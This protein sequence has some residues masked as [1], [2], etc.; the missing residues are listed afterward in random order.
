MSSRSSGELGD[1]MYDTPSVSLVSVSSPAIAVE[2]GEP[3]AAEAAVTC[4]FAF[5]SMFSVLLFLAG[6]PLV[7]MGVL[8]LTGVTT[9]LIESALAARRRRSAATAARALAVPERIAGREARETYRAILHVYAEIQRE[10]SDAVT[11]RASRA[12][13]IERCAAAVNQCS[14][15]AVLCNPLQRYLDAHDR[16]AAVAETERL[17]VRSEIAVDPLAG[18]ALGRAAEARTRQ[19]ATHDEIT[20]MHERILARLE[21][22][23][24]ALESFAATIVKL[25]VAGEEQRLLSGTSV[26]EHLEGVGDELDVIETELALDL[27]A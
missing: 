17:H 5:T 8:A 13:V 24:A 15:M 1:I 26:L 9:L 25:R 21:L 3:G 6:M 22:V 23:R 18:E 7:S 2:H 16:A 11:L 14:R 4:G 12:V 27:A 19:L 20:R 10:L